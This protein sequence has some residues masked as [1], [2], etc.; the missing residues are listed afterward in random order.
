MVMVSGKHKSK[1]KP[2]LSSQAYMGQFSMRRTILI[3]GSA[4][5]LG[6]AL[7]RA[8]AGDGHRI[9]IHFRSSRAEAEE[10]LKAIQGDGG[11][12]ALLSGIR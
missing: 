1:T 4:K 10:T 5:R 2:L 8:L 7:A 12:A 3:T 11:E 9:A 6:A